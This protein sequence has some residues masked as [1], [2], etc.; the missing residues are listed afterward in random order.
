MQTSDCCLYMSPLLSAVAD[1]LHDPLEAVIRNAFMSIPASSI[2][3][4]RVVDRRPI[5]SSSPPSSSSSSSALPCQ[6]L[7]GPHHCR[8]LNELLEPLKV[9]APHAIHEAAALPGLPLES[10]RDGAPLARERP[11][12]QLPLV[13]PLPPRAPAVGALEA[14]EPAEEVVPARVA[15]SIPE[16]QQR[17][18]GRKE[19]NEGMMGNMDNSRGTRG[20][21]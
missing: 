18:R 17:S 21:L 20:C 7:Q 2:T 11:I 12:K 4:N 1:H 15:M 5:G 14:G 9:P 13:L 8:A 10:S 6:A 16:E 19:G 3:P